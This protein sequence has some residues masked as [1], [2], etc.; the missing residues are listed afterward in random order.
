MPRNP[1][2][3]SPPPGTSLVTCPKCGHEYPDHEDYS[4][5]AHSERDCIE[6]LRGLLA[7]VYRELNT[8]SALTIAP[9]RID[10]LTLQL[11]RVRLALD[12]LV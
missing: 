8:I 10:E 12:G 5:P 11:Q 4:G 2:D 1:Y 3:F 6:V 7:G 9:G